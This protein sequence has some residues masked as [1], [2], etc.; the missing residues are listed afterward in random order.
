MAQILLHLRD[1]ELTFGGKPLPEAAELAVSEGE[2][3]ALV[4][5][6]GSGKSTLLK[7][8]AGL[9]EP[10][11]GERFAHPGARIAYL[12]QEADLSGYATTLAY[13]E[14]GLGPAD[15]AY[16]GRALLG[17]LGLTGAERPEDLSGGEARR[18]AIARALAARP[19][20]RLIDEPTT[21][22]DLPPVEV[23]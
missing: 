8:A 11:R 21:H 7:I 22:P 16:R 19:D 3:I 1:I 6:S 4:G 15:D 18:A 13:L 14:A 20:V 5:A 10:D 2:R 17:V 23:L 12:A 9:I